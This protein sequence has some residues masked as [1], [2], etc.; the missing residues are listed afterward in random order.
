[1]AWRPQIFAP[2]YKI[3]QSYEVWI[4]QH[5]D[6]DYLSKQPIRFQKSAGIIGLLHIQF[7]CSTRESSFDEAPIQ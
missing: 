7:S 5:N 4:F 2:I 6:L 3:L 1:M